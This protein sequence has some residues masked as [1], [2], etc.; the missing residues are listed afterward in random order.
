MRFELSLG[1]KRPPFGGSFG[2]YSPRSSKELVHYETVK[3][4]PQSDLGA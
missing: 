3:L 1:P 2:A 4:S